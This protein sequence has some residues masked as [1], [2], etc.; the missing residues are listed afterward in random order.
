MELSLEHAPENIAVIMY[1]FFI[2]LVRLS[3]SMC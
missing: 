1:G 3:K 2:K